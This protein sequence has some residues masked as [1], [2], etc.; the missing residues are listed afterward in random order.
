MH[1]ILMCGGFATR[2]EPITYFIPK[3]LLPIGVGGK[4][5]IEYIL[6]D[7]IA[8]GIKDVVITANSKFINHFEYWSKHRLDGNGAR[9]KFVVEKTMHNNEK[10]GQVKGISHAIE[11]AGIKDDIIVIAGDNLFDFSIKDIISHFERTKR[12]VVGL[13]DIKSKD[14]AKKLGVVEINGTKITAFA[15][16][17]PE[18]KSTLI[19]TGIYV[20]PKEMLGKFNEYLGNGKNPDAIGH[21]IEWLIT[22]TE[23]E[24]H[25]Y[26]GK[27]H[28]IGTLE[29]YRQVFDEYSA[30][31]KQG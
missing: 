16:K 17:P 13:Y 11:K 22:N 2:L 12:P 15:E 9:I 5:I 24:G 14:L 30:A 29:I 21:F 25:V 31:H 1:A 27:W 6:D 26:S 18:P 19:S 4:P 7:V 8:S 3:P 20:I 28:D 10:F 23:V